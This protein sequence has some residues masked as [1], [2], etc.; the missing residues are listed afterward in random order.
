MKKILFI[1]LFSLTFVH[2]YGQDK[3]SDRR[4]A[5]MALKVGMITEKV[6]LTADQ[7]ENFWPVYNE[8]SHEKRELNRNMRR[9]MHKSTQDELTDKDRM[10][11]QDK[12]LKLREAEIDLTKKYRERLLKIINPKQY[13]DLQVAEE[14]FNRMLLEE[15]RKRKERSNN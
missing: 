3:K 15:L 11:S 12:I 2:S 4:E 14:S 10:A 6:N 1:L 5:L 7:A 13:A 8:Y 9:E